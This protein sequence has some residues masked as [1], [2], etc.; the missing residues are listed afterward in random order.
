M[1]TIFQL[2]KGKKEKKKP[3]KRPALQRC[4]QKK[5][6]CIKIL[7]RTPKK[8]NSARRKISKVYL[9]TRKFIFGYIAGERQRLREHAV[10]LVRG[11]RTQDLPGLKYKLI[12]GKLDFEPDFNRR[13]RRSLYGV[14]LVRVERRI[15]NTK[16]TKK[17]RLK[18]KKGEL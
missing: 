1:S 17:Y 2:I 9:T 10:V 18:K 11:G 4:P 13:H 16:F 14:F 8:P 3:S 5:G 7:E 12:R 15:D 6:I